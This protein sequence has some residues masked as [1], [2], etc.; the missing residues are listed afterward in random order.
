MT[1]RLVTDCSANI[2]GNITEDIAYVPLKIVTKEKE[3]VD[4]PSLNVPEMLVELKAYKGT[5]GT[6]C[7]GIQDWLDAFGDHDMVLGAVITSGLSGAYGSARI[8]QEEYREKHPEGK[9]YIHDSLSTGPELELLMEKYQELVQNHVPFEDICREIQRY[10]QRTH[11]VF[12]LESLENFAKNGRVSPVVAKAA[13]LLGLRIV[14]KASDAGTLEPLH[15]CRGEKKALAQLLETMCSLG[16]AGGKVRIS[17]SYN[18]TAARAVADLIRAGYPQSDISITLNR[19][20]CC[21]YAEAGSILIG[22]EGQ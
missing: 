10:N 5:S 2:C 17:H 4:T 12:S 13:G 16:F 9:I 8:A 3:Y 7:P 19:G 22:F 14:G 15:K 20:L 21:Y 18:E 1:V 6:A 11:L